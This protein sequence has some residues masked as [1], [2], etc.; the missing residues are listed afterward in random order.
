MLATASGGTRDVYSF[1]EASWRGNSR[2]DKIRIEA[3]LAALNGFSV[4]PQGNFIDTLPP[5]RINSKLPLP[6]GCIEFQTLDQ[7]AAVRRFD[8]GDQST[9]L[10]VNIRAKDACNDPIGGLGPGS[11]CLQFNCQRRAEIDTLTRLTL[12]GF[13]ICADDY[14]VGANVFELGNR[15][16]ENSIRGRLARLET[17][18]PDFPS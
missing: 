4:D 17:L 16:F 15:F 11:C 3:E 5:H 6:H 1:G 13:S 10:N 14:I 12:K 8:F 7:C 2:F 18:G 9:F